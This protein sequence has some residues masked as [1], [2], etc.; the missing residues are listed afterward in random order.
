MSARI[1]VVDDDPDLLFLMR[2][3]L[4]REGWEILTANGGV[5]ALQMADRFLPE[6]ILLDMMMPD[7][8][9]HEV[10]AR[11]RADA[12]FRHIPILAFTAM[13]QAREHDIARRAGVNDIIL[14]PIAPQ[15]LFQRLQPFL[16]P[17]AVGN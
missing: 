9:G 11:L 7:M 6:L 1:L 5:E 3:V 2:L 4:K 8:S 12:R 17:P 10:C 16:A 15:D 14:K 13:A